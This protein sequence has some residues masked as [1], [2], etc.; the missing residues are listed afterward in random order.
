MGSGERSTFHLLLRRLLGPALGLALTVWLLVRIEWSG[1]VQSWRLITPAWWL[2]SFV[3]GILSQIV[4]ALRWRYLL[5]PVD[6]IPM[7]RLVSA[8][9]VGQAA[10][11]LLPFRLGE[12]GSAYALSRMHPVAFT[13]VIGSVVTDR[14][15]DIV[16]LLCAILFLLS[17]LSITT[18]V[19]PQALFGTTVVI[20]RSIM[21][22]AAQAFGVL[23]AVV[24]LLL[25]IFRIWRSPWIYCLHR[26]LDPVSRSVVF[27]IEHV[28]ITFNEGLDA[29]RGGRHLGIVVITTLAYWALGQLGVWLLIGSYPLGTPPS[30]SLSLLVLV[31]VA[32]GL[33]LPNAPGYVGTLHLAVVMGLLLGNPRIDLGR[34]LGFAVYYHLSAFL[35][36]VLLG[37][38][39]AWRDG[40]TILPS[41]SPGS[42]KS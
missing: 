3:A 29:L 36:C 12:A 13:T 9:F 8:L 25:L 17:Y 6:V 18:V 1:L 34:A 2:A 38:Y 16:W 22:H 30:L 21:I 42:G 33:A 19:I 39:F 37:L 23:L 27:R 20:S 28:F 5:L 40:L 24:G 41:L 32:A 31:S 11:W 14:L 26:V 15:L 4:R 10:T 35:P 7:R